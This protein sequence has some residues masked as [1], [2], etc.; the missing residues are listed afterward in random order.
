MLT[1]VLQAVNS[2]DLQ[3]FA[4]TVKPVLS[5]RSKIDRTKVLKTN[6]SSM[7]VESNAKYSLGAFCN[8]FDLHLAPICLNDLCV[9]L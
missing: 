9:Y 8:T 6:G 3:V 2:I 4:H 7:K 1:T 5:S